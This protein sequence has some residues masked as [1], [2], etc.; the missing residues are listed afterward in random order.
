MSRH[1]FSLW[2]FA[3]VFGLSLI[4]FTSVVRTL[5]AQSTGT[6]SVGNSP[7][8]KP[9]PAQAQ[10]FVE[11]ANEILLD[12]TTKA[13]RA[14]WVQATYITDDTQ[15][16][17]AEANDRLI[18]ATTR[19]IK[20]ATRFDGLDL[21]PDTARQLKLLKLSL[22][23]PAPSDPKEREELTRIAA[24]LEAEYGKGEYRP[25]SGPFA[26][27]RLGQSEMEEAFA[28]TRD[29]AVLLDLW[30]GWRSFSPSLKQP[31]ARFVELSNKGARE[32]GYQ[33]VGALW[34]SN[35][36][37]PAEQFEQEVHRL[38]E[39]VKPLYVSLHAYVRRKLSE[40]YGPEVVPPDG[41][42]PA[43]LLGNIWAQEWGNISELV[44]PGNQPKPYDLTALLKAQNVDPV[45]MVRIGERF[46]LSLGFDPLPETFWERSLFTKP[47]DRNVVCHASAWN[48]DSENDLRLKMCIQVRDDDFVTVHHE[49][50]H[51]FYQRAYNH[52][53]FLFRNGANDGFHEAIGDALALSITPGYL[54]KVGL[55][56]E[57]PRIDEA[58]DI[59]FLLREGL[60]KIAFLPFGL[61]IDEWRW[62]VFS[63]EVG[64]EN[65]NEAWWKLR[66]QYQGIAAPAPRSEQD[67]DPGAKYHVPG[68][69]PYIRYFLARLLQFQFHRGLCRAAG[70]TGPLHRCSIYESKEAGEKLK[71]MLAMGQSR[72]WPEA[73]TALTG[74][75]RIDAGAMLEY[76]EPLKKWLDEQN[77]GHPVGW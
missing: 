10:E 65:Y 47:A 35:Y 6:A 16:L 31:Y 54:H 48:I 36:D 64:P 21:P 27:Q 41:M 13:A 1:L 70:H 74:E 43:H 51:N 45:G 15:A 30:L 14:A 62:K 77:H 75:D 11:K 28:T 24:K 20:E 69:T 61:L 4:V 50:G 22:T 60:D 52:L 2:A 56:K 23:M 58:A 46:F 72:P 59:S 53:P 32:I 38:W 8:G 73:L 57:Q 76:F 55:L 12:L 40:R 3:A 49:L 29:P 37:M 25:E 68:N 33:D 9:T 42:I 39:Q 26:G 19:L 5:S 44:L 34:R 7:D 71:A 67:F 18:E 63:G 17:A 66:N